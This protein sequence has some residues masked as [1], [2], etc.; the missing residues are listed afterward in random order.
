MDSHRH[1]DETQSPE[2]SQRSE[3]AATL[4]DGDSA[5]RPVL[6]ASNRT[7]MDLIPTIAPR[8]LA[9]NR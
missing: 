2:G 3:E 5:A 4:R 1:A 6:H 7:A 9:P 8:S